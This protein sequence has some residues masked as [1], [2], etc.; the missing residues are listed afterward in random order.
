MVTRVTLLQN[1]L[2]Y[3]LHKI[4]ISLNMAEKRGRSTSQQ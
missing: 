3:K 2:K 1:K 4:V